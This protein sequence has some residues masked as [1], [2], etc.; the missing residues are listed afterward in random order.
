MFEHVPPCCGCTILL[1]GPLPLEF[2]QTKQYHLFSDPADPCSKCFTPTNLQTWTHSTILLATCD[3]DGHRSISSY[4]SMR[5]W[6]VYLGLRSW[7][8]SDASLI[9]IW[10]LSLTHF[11]H[12]LDMEKSHV[13]VS[14]VRPC[15]F[16]V[17][18]RQ[19]VEELF[20]Q[21]VTWWW[22]QESKSSNQSSYRRRSTVVDILGHFLSP[23]FQQNKYELK[24]M[25]S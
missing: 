5:H 12:A 23:G 22:H 21:V 2:I 17:A 24:T 11:I 4:W 6:T 18:H 8:A 25:K 15:E 7:D 3:T 10:N 9:N 13:W 1:S 19:V 20:A 14:D 16:A